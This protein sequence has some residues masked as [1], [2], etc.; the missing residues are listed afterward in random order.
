[1][2]EVVLVHRDQKTQ[3]F[4]VGEAGPGHERVQGFEGGL[5]SCVS[6]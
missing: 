4:I 2:D 3:K 1:M 5:G 6:V